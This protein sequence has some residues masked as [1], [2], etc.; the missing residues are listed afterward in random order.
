MDA[1]D[2]RWKGHRLGRRR[3]S[4]RSTRE[5]RAWWG[6]GFGL[7][8]RQEGCTN[9]SSWYL[10]PGIGR[11]NKAWQCIR[12]NAMNVVC[13]AA[14]RWALDSVSQS[15]SK[16]NEIGATCVVSTSASSVWS[17][18]YLWAAAGSL[19]CSWIIPILFRYNRSL[20][21]PE[22]LVRSNHGSF[23]SKLPNMVSIL[24]KLNNHHIEF[25]A[26]YIWF[27]FSQLP[28]GLI[29]TTFKLWHQPIWHI[30]LT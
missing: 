1:H 13:T 24:L 20:E 30:F 9:S 28:P 17:F 27:I 4:T 14:I 2:R 26:C 21:I 23:C 12:S 10:G 25:P 11:R 16:R 22:D 19:D 29:C 5:I 8:R 18:C 6:Y 3:W 7:S 15:I